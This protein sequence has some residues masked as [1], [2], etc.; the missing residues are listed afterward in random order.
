MTEPYQV[1]YQGDSRLMTWPAPM[2]RSIITD[3]PFGVDNQSN[4]AKTVEG[5][6]EARKIA[7][8]E[9][10]EIAL[11]CTKAALAAA[12]PG[13]LPESDIYVF[14][15]QQV[16]DYWLAELPPFLAHW[17]F[18]YK[19]LGMWIKEGP[20]MGDLKSWG[21]GHELILYFKRGTRVISIP[22]QSLIF[23]DP[24]IRP[25]NL[26]HPHEK[27]RGILKKMIDASTAPGELVYDP[28]GGSASLAMAAKEL[29]RSC[30]CIEYDDLNF[31]RANERLT[32][33]ENSLFS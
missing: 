10:P 9:T 22:R 29:G 17:Q 18:T 26:I 20:G 27:P 19:A 21:N 15:S 28:F 25:A 1:I 5:K 23:T 32:T 2:I 4:Q 12:M 16:L 31:K 6:A 13:M 24:Q 7:N 11:E 8:D 30:V 3:P 14:T 33:S